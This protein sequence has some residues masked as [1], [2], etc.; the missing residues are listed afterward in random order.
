MLAFLTHSKHFKIVFVE[1]NPYSKFASVELSLE[2]I[3]LQAFMSKE[4]KSTGFPDLLVKDKC[5]INWYFNYSWVG[6]ML[7]LEYT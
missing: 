5:I 1:L 3:L 2:F 4:K 7:S 6:L